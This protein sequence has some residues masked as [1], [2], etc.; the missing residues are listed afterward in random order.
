MASLKQQLWDPIAGFGVTFTTMFR[1]VFT[2]QYPF[3]KKPTAPRFH[4]RHQLNRHPDGLEKCVGCELCAWACPADAIYVEGA[5]NT[6]GGRFSPGERYGRVYQINYLR[7]ILCGL[8]IE[9]CPTRALTMTNE[10]ELADDNRADLIYEKKDL[11]A[12]LLPGME[13]PPHEMRL[14][15][16]EKDYYMGA[17]LPGWSGRGGSEQDEKDT[18]DGNDTNVESEAAHS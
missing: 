1:K 7:C 10:Y 2:E 5:D 15:D 9:A 14:G 11:L 18:K 17:G 16:D 13:E 4:G 3:E 12:P 8:C 6:E